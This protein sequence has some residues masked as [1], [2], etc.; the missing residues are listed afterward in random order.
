M[1]GLS[2]E[3]CLSERM[4]ETGLCFTG[5]TVDV[6]D[7]SAVLRRRAVEEFFIP[8]FSLHLANHALGSP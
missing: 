5:K 7:D 4:E 8:S 6:V 3:S 1:C 2:K